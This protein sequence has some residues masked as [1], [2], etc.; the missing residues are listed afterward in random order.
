MSLQT[1][2]LVF[3]LVGVGFFLSWGYSGEQAN[4]TIDVIV[5]AIFSVIGFGLMR[6]TPVL[7][8]TD[9]VL[10]VANQIMD[11]GAAKLVSSFEPEERVKLI[12]AHARKATR[13]IRENAQMRIEKIARELGTNPSEGNQS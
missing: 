10:R 12:R 13:E 5:G 8:T 4:L 9:R 7:K 2:G 6:Y 11:E 1:I 3:L